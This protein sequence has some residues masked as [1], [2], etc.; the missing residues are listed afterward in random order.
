MPKVL[1]SD[2]I[3]QDGI[4][5]LAGHAQVDVRLGLPKEELIA[6]IGE[7]DALVVRSGTQVTA[8]VI[9][10]GKRLQVVGRAGMGGDNIDLQAATRCGGIVVNAPLGNTI[11]A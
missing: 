4:D 2:P 10:A 1:V 11:C 9:E 5:A 6:A 8:E 7:Y 3:A